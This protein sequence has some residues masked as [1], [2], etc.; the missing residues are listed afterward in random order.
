MI[1]PPPSCAGVYIWGKDWIQAKTQAECYDY[2]FASALEM[3]KLGIDASRP[4]AAPRLPEP[5]SAAATNGRGAA[6]EVPAEATAPAAKR[7]RRE[8]YGAKLPTCVILDI[9]GT[10]AP[11]SFVSEVMFPYARVHARSHLEQTFGSSETT[12]DVQLIRQ[13][14]RIALGP[15]GRCLGPEEERVLS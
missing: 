9:E 10:V 5:T 8:R 1:R 11:I 7:Q 3:H 14:V 2:L 15:E 4:P 12:E 13:Q 6:L